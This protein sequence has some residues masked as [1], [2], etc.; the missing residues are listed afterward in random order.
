MNLH[1]YY[2]FWT[3]TSYTVWKISYAFGPDSFVESGGNAYICSSHL[4]GKFLDLFE[5]PRG[6]LLETYFLDVLVNADGVFFGHYLVDGRMVLLFL[7][8]FLFRNHYAGS[9]LERSI[10]KHFLNTY[11]MYVC[12]L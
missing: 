9:K 5:C 11:S 6:T 8:V 2:V 12:C 7:T 4:Y 1:P 10:S 3:T